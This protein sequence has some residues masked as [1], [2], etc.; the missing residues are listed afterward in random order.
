MS[1]CAP[2]AKQAELMSGTI[3][4]QDLE[5]GFYGIIR[6]DGESLLPQNLPEEFRRDGLAVRFSGREIQDVYTIQ[7]WG[8][9]FELTEIQRAK[10]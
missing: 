7:Q 6:E 3:T 9:P 4:Y 10:P 2:P 1:A 8:T 5:G